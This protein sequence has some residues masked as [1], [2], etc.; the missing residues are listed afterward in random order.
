MP[1]QAAVT[2]GDAW[3]QASRRIE[4]LDARLLL[5][6]VCACAHAELIA[7]PERAMGADEESA[8]AALVARRAAGEPL[9]YLL[10]SAWFHGL[11]FAVGPAVLVP[12]PETEL[13]VDLAANRVGAFV[14]PRILDLGTGSGIVAIVLARL[15][16][17][18]AVTA[19]DLS[20]PALATARANAARH[21]A[22]VRFLAGDWYAPLGEERFDLIVSNPPYI[23]A[24]D[25][26]LRGD[27]L[28]CEPPMALT[29]GQAG[30][31]GLACIRAIV[32]AAPAHL[33]PGGWLLLEHGYDQAVE[34]RSLMHN[35]G[36]GAPESWCDAAG[37]ER[38]SGGRRPA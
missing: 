31:N 4:R 11:E 3:R 12:R 27:G 14:A 6:H 37:I 19:V 8:Y 10:G 29:D 17:Q 23:A 21:A 15:C 28:C 35:A 13:L 22:E 34:V 24:G 20:E 18:A 32:A 7:H 1:G 25:P 5:Q 30:G 16:P 36:F 2:W 9:A 33:R 38:V 26:H